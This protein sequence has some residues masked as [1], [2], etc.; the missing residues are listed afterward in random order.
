[1]HA[2]ITARTVGIPIVAIVLLVV[3]YGRDLA[4]WVVALVAV[5]LVAAVLIAVH[6][7][8]VVAHR[9]G[10][11]F[12]SLILAVAVTVIEVGLIL[13][14]AASGGPDTASLARDTVFAAVMITCNGIVGLCLLIGAVRHHVVS[15]HAEGSS[16]ALAA[17]VTLSVLCLVLPSF[18]TTSAGPT[19]SGPQLAFT[20]IVSIVLYG[21]YVFVQ[22]VR[23][24]DYFL[25]IEDGPDSPD[26]QDHDGHVDP[27]SDRAAWISLGL[28]VL[29][30]VA[31]VGLAKTISPTIEAGVAAIGAP[32]AVVGVAI[33]LLVLLPET[34]AAARAAFRDRLQTSLNL[35]YGS[36]LA[37]I[38]LTIPS[39]AV[40][41][42]W[43]V[44]PLQLGLS[45]TE[46][47]LLA[48]TGLVGSLTVLRGTA[49]VLQ[50]VMHLMIFA[51]F[52]FIAV[53]P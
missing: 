3:V 5:A 12:G 44:D 31:V 49:I 15:F 34:L 25:P 19:F 41:S 21:V 37:S 1:M 45:G 20:A 42:I 43:F 26:D 46:V 16:G 40:A 50:G 30:L 17:V 36:A 4:G 33:A 28:L 18:T 11:P 24:R 29:S 2:P 53:S 8:E 39:I 47:V 32:V 13:S 35:A 10:E 51:S 38:G 9:V 52:L 22:T 7:A 14:I 23:H 27:P 48:L 6:H